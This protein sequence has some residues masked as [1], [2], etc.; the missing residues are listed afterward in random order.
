VPVDIK[1]L[2]AKFPSILC[3]GVVVPNPFHGVEH[4]IH[5]GGHPPVFAKVCRLDPEKL[6]IAKADH[7]R[8][9]AAEGSLTS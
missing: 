6:E 3:T 1:T 5:T 2:L 9:T 4:H 8:L 7:Q